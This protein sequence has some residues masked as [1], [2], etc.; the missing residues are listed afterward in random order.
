MKKTTAI[1]GAG[2]HAKVVAEIL[3]LNGHEI[4]GFLD[5]V[6]ASRKG[7]TF[8]GSTVLGGSEVLPELL[9]KGI[10][11]FIVAFGNNEARV[12]TAGELVQLGFRLATAIHP[13]AVC[14]AD[15]S[16]GEGSVIAPGAVIGPS[17]KVGQ[18]AIVNT[19]ASLDHDCTVMDGAHI[20]PGAVIT[21]C[22]EIGRCAWVGA[23]AVVSDHKRIGKDSIVGA[24]AV[25]LQDVGEEVIV[26]GVPAR[27]LRKVHE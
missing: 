4:V 12:R 17:T 1:W 5:T 24:G 19:Q 22:V 25:V 18:N 8:Y 20:G 26:V 15:A 23:G 3:R 7:A 27:L 11:D 16:I 13:S 2:G 9:G 21:G 14:A 6:D 10:R